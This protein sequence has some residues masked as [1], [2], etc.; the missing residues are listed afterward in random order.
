MRTVYDAGYFQARIVP[1][2]RLMCIIIALV[3]LDSQHRVICPVPGVIPQ[4]V[5]VDMHNRLH[6]LALVLLVGLVASLSVHVMAVVLPS[7]FLPVIVVLLIE[8]SLTAQ[9]IMY[10]NWAGVAAAPSLA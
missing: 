10:S 5:L 9:W 6:Q 4:L 7:S 8:N 3:S 1:Y 2:H